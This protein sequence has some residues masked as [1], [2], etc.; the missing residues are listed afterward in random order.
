MAI[1]RLAD[2]T[3]PPFGASVLNAENQEIGIVNDEG[4]A[5][6]SGLQPGHQLRVS[7]NGNVQ[8]AVT[9]PKNLQGTSQNGNLLLPCR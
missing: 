2:G 9:L 3:Y 4:Q 8:C 5:Y 6:L 1:I 7:W